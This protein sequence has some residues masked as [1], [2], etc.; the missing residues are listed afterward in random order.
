MPAPASADEL[1]ALMRQSGIVEPNR[2]TA[3]LPELPQLP[4]EAARV[5]VREGWLTYFHA[6]QLLKGKWRGFSI[7]KYQILE[8]LGFGGMGIVYL[9]E[10]KALRRRVAVKVLPI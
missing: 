5:L 6:E 4:K 9:A 10:H 7:G 2:L 8:R 3:G 1:V